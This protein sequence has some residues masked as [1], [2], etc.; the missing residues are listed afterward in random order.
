MAGLYIHIPFCGSRCLYCDFF[1]TTL[2]DL[3]DKYVDCLCKEL[4]IRQLQEQIQT[5]YFGGGTPSLL[6][7][8]HILQILTRIKNLYSLS[9]DC[10]ITLE[11]NPQDLSKEY[12]TAISKNGINRLSIGCQSF[13]EAQLRFLNRRHTAKQAY[14]AVCTAHDCGFENISIDLIYG[15]PAQTMKD[16]EYDIQTALSLPVKHISCYCLTIEENTPL[17]KLFLKDKSLQQDDDTLN[18]MYFLLCNRLKN[19]YHYEISNFA[20]DEK[21][22]SRHNSSYWN[23]IPYLG[24]GAG[25]HSYDGN[26]MRSW[27]ISNLQKYIYSIEQGILPLE[28]ET[29]NLQD[30]ITEL[31]MLRLRTR[32]GIDLSVINN[33]LRESI[34]RKAQTYIENG[35][36][37]VADNHLSATQEGIKILNLII[38]DL[39]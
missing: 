28:N 19:W 39:I 12:L 13:Q 4:E 18:E 1:S 32:E 26:S 17:H 31:I 33:E 25:A 35:K 16:W 38:E 11:A 14:Q 7:P 6:S 27:N 37:K 5:I 20:I 24:I 8:T 30:K 36:L 10:E 2:L 15:L 22:I 34:L 9:S 21:H 23:N 3:R 29:L